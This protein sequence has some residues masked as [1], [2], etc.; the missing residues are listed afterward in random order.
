MNSAGR[1][2][3]DHLQGPAHT[4][5]NADHFVTYV[6]LAEPEGSLEVELFSSD[7]ESCLADVST[8][9]Y[10]Q[11]KQRFGGLLADHVVVM[12]QTMTSAMC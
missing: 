9:R 6:D 4:R 10:K 1:A 7:D 8:G 3:A 12:R 2:A 11:L 5:Q